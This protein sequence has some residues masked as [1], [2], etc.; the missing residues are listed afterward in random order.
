MEDQNL[1]TELFKIIEEV[2]ISGT[3]SFPQRY[4]KYDA[5]DLLSKLTWDN[6]EL[7]NKLV[8]G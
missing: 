7:T 2:K 6:V 5:G 4:G 8:K 1:L 3:L